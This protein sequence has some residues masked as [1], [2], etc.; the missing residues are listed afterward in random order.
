V[1]NGT[2]DNDMTVPSAARMADYLLGDGRNLEADR[3]LADL[4]ERTVPDIALV[5]RMNRAFTR[6]AVS[7]LVAAGVRQFL[8]L[9][10]GTTAVG[11]VHEVAQAVDPGCRVVYVHRNPVAVA[12][13]RQ[14]IENVAG[15]AVLEASPRDAEPILGICHADGLLDLTRPV[16][17][18]MVGVLPLL[19]DSTNLV[20]MVAGYRERIVP[21]SYL[22]ISHLTGDQRPEE[23]AAMVQM[24]RASVDSVHPRTREEVVRLF[25]GFE[26]VAP[27]VVDAG[28]WH[29]ERPLDPAE[30]LASLLLYAGVG[31]KPERPA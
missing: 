25:T 21:D 5:V 15:T 22:V 12:Y 27:G 26:L 20:K 1:V 13:T 2:D 24:M 8:D 7:Y 29:A 9:T 19:P 16:G 31:R 23:T 3:R 4:I 6:R 30:E 28:R 11:N 10:V 17:V 18:L 14:L